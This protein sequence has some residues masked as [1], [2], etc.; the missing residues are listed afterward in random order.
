MKNPKVDIIMG[1][2]N[3]EK[4]L[5]ESIDSI[6]AQT[7]NNWRLIICDDGSSDSTYKIAEKYSND[8]S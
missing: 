6:L 7:Y 5:A 1:V 3:C 4:Y 8:G 2:Y